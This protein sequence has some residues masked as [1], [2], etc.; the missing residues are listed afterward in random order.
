MMHTKDLYTEQT[1]IGVYTGD[2]YFAVPV[3]ENPTM[4]R[5]ELCLKDIC[6][7]IFDE[8]QPSKFTIQNIADLDRD[9]LLN[10]YEENEIKYCQ[11]IDALEE[12]F[13]ETINN[14]KTEISMLKDIINK[15]KPPS[16]VPTLISPKPGVKKA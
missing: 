8:F 1:I 5:L 2:H 12:N 3:Q 9:E 11:M 14:L 16:P 13:N 4:D 7:Q 15:S 6:N 10:K